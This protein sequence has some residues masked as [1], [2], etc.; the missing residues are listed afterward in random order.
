VP[1]G[2]VLKPREAIAILAAL[3]FKEARQRG[4]PAQKSSFCGFEEDFFCEIRHGREHRF[5][6][7]G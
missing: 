1:S 7:R 3:G 6:Y 4:R 5:G 2:P